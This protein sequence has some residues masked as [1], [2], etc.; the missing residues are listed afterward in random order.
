MNQLT[1]KFNIEQIS[2]KIKDDIDLQNAYLSNSYFYNSLT[3]CVIDS[4]FSI[5]V[6]YSSVL[7]TVNNYAEFFKLK[8]HRLRTLDGYPNIQDQELLSDLIKNIDSLS[9]D[10]LP[11]LLTP[12]KG[13]F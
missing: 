1:D 8:K 3:F 13:K 5:G 11:L 9:I 2:K 4:V 6:R 7:N 12:P 10:F